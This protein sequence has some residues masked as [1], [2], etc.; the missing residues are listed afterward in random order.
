MS[1]IDTFGGKKARLREEVDE[2]LA[3]HYFPGPE[4]N[5]KHHLMPSHQ[6]DKAHAVMLYEEGLMARDV[7]VKIL[8]ALKEMESQGVEKTRL[9][10]GG[11]AHTGEL[12]ITKKY[13]ENIGGRL[14][15]GRSSG[16]LD[17]VY[18]TFVLRDKLLLMMDAN[19]A[20]RSTLIE[21]AEKHVDTVMLLFSFH[22]PAQATT[23]GHY[24]IAWA[25]VAE[26]NFER[27]VNL[28]VRNN[29]SPAG[30]A[31]GTGSEFPLNRSRVAEL[32]GYDGVSKNTRDSIFNLDG[33]LEGHSI[34]SIM[35]NDL[36]RF[37]DDLQLWTTAEFDWIE[38]ADRY[39]NTSSIMPQKKN[40]KA[41][42]YIRGIS[43]VTLGHLV[44]AFATMK[45]TSDTIEP[46]EFVPWE[47]WK[48]VDASLSAIK[49][50]TGV[51]KTITVKP[52]HMLAD[53]GKT[54]VFASDL[55]GMIVRKK[56]LPFRTAHQIVAIM[57]RES[58]DEGKNPMTIT[59]ETIDRAA[60]EHTGHALGLDQ[61]N[62]NEVLDHRNRIKMRTLMGGVAPEEVRKQIVEARKVLERDSAY[63]K[64]LRG[65]LE[66]RSK[67]LE[68][69]ISE[70]I[71]G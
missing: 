46:H 41:L 47:L 50:M 44:T 49:I 70:I 29:I 53:V 37:A 59:A 18:R 58:I 6:F 7:A 60:V 62:I 66:E 36:G 19:L 71:S 8:S 20:Y 22:Q 48:S 34:I 4:E 17:A 52:E 11:S 42:E 9:K 31:I 51:L 25:C 1:G 5:I 54:W 10:L 23:F 64:K 14:H 24:L 3:R 12:Y 61:E 28:Y 69:A 16:D 27:F 57:V 68:K 43:A 35:C 15:I 30:A 32:L 39:C 40:P 65:I 21:L 45:S 13:G 38:L 55:A 56:G 2:E 67:V 26:R 33:M 63:L